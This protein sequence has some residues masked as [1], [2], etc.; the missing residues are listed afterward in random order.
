MSDLTYPSMADLIAALQTE[1]IRRLSLLGLRE[2]TALAA[3]ESTS[4]WRELVQKPGLYLHAF[5]DDEVFQMITDDLRSRFE[6]GASRLLA[7]NIEVYI[8][9]TELRIDRS[10]VIEFALA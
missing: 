7:N 6:S 4:I 10:P 1:M 2:T 9:R 8:G 5:S 3:L